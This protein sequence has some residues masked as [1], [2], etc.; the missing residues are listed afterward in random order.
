[1][2]KKN[3]KTLII[4]AL[5]ILSIP[6]VFVVA[7]Y[8]GVFG[9]LQ[10]K[11]ELLNFKNATATSILSSE[12]K[13][14][15]NIFSE[16]R[17]NISYGQIP[18]NLIN[19]LIATEDSRF[20]EHKGI[21]SRSLFRV[22]FKTL[23]L[24]D[25]SSG[26]GSTISQQLAKNMFGRK[27]TGRLTLLITKT[28]E[29]I[30]AHRLEKSFSKEEILTLYL[31]TV[32]FGENIF[33]IGTA[34]RRYF[35]TK[36]EL[37]KPEESAILVGILKANTLYNPRLHPGNAVARRNVVLR[38]MAKYN[39]L[40][41]SQ[42][43]SLCKLPLIQNFKDI[44]SDGPADY[45]LIHV[46]N[47]TEKILQSVQ[48]VT[49][50]KWNIEEDGL[51]ITTTLNLTLQKYALE[52]FREHLSVMQKRLR[53]QYQTPSGKKLI[54]QLVEQELKNLNME[55]RAGEVNIRQIFDWN[56]SHSDSVT[57]A[58]SMKQAL[59]ILHAGLLAMD[60]QTGSVKAWVGGVDFKSQQYDQ[61]LAMRQL[62]STFKPILFAEAFELGLQPCQYLD[63]DSVPPSGDDEWSPVNYD[64]TSGGKYSLAGALVHS[65]NIPTYNLFLNVG[66]DNLD[67]LWRKL[68][69]SF[70]L[71][72][73]PALALGTAEGSIM[74]TA[75]A[76]SAFANG[77]YR[78]E[79]QIIIS[80]KSPDGE[81]IW[82]N[83][84][85]NQKE[86]VLT[87][88]SSLLISAI[89]QKA[90]REG[91][92]SALGSEYGINLP[93]AGKT[94]TS[95]D[96]SDAWFTAFNPNLV[97]VTRVGA[98]SRAIH[99]N[100]GSYGS[101]STLALP[102][103]ALTLKKVQ[104]NDTL[105]HQLIGLFPDLPADLQGALDCPDF[106]EKNIVN[107]FMD[108]FHNK[109]IYRNEGTKG[110]NHKKKGF[111]RRLFGR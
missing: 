101:G 84:F 16:N 59:L 24:N 42:A 94:G 54:G 75:M 90:V 69:F 105:V 32:S 80:I 108:L 58:D 9:H 72:N 27:K 64:H 71:V 60:P 1:M 91:T 45:F 65:M 98:S 49:G 50:K 37:L 39:Y 68:G 36:V 21:D 67:S 111:F 79:P 89:L 77:G 48:S 30:L 8:S 57:V 44:E 81:I 93:I 33:G 70:A 86:R 12:G 76:Y 35:N 5:V 88:R 96:F 104:D 51:I 66:F 26:G 15:G 83:Q 95:Q 56:G 2:F 53:E 78:I 10:T 82:Q 99:F 4:I 18:A 41:P 19:A 46:K 43:D 109:K 63:N 107:K 25:R 20:F 102:L 92:G 47:E 23:I 87:E 17:T 100:N 97:I 28:K 11:K 73:T 103:V 14:I 61:I 38:Q 55:E 34:S 6:V 3:W 7:V 106:K 74:E 22:L 13:L 85:N 31:N 52:S 110:S 29:A 62:A 40:K